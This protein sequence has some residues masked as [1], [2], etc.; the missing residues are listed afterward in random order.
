LKKRTKKLLW[1][2]RFNVPGHGRQASAA[3][4]NKSLLLLFFRKEVLPYF[5]KTGVNPV[6]RKQPFFLA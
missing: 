3:P 4:E 5:S 1:L 6:T 2:G